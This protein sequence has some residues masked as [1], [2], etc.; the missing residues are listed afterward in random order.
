M[1]SL[2]CPSSSEMG[3]GDGQSVRNSSR[4]AAVDSEGDTAVTPA[5]GI[6]SYAASEGKDQGGT[7]AG[8]AG[9]RV[10]WCYQTEDDL[11]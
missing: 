5:G 3:V 4:Q 2:I 7:P 9:A 6:V 1:K 11:E 8:R 10:S